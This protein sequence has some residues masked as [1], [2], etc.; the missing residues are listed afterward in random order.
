MGSR[1]LEITLK[2][3]VRAIGNSKFK[4]QI[5]LKGG[6]NLE[7]ALIKY[8]SPIN[9]RPTV[10]ADFQLFSEDILESLLAEIPHLE[11][12]LNLKYK[13]FD[14]RGLDKTPN[15]DSI[16]IETDLGVKFEVD[17]NIS[18]YKV[19]V[20]VFDIEYPLG[21][22][23]ESMLADKLKV[24]YSKK[25]YRRSKDL[26]DLYLLSVAKNFK[27]IA[28]K[29]V[30]LDKWENTVFPEMPLHSAN[31]DD[32]K[33]AYNKLSGI[34]DKLEFEE[35]YKKVFEFT[36]PLI[37]FIFSKAADDLQW[38]ANKREWVECG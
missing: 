30:I 2:D 15:S 14:R 25:I 24:F 20:E 21:Y 26:Y 27:L 33:Y 31:L 11:S 36:T 5:I 12:Q 8:N 3:F 6:L 35:I 16:T 19:D 34:G 13:V 29:S 28:T 18:K 1:T 7:V 22:S 10:D 23:M 32:L 4:R 9:A 38:D 17:I 37:G